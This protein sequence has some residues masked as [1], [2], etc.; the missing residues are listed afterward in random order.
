MHARCLGASTD[1]CQRQD[2]R[3]LDTNGT[4]RLPDWWARFSSQTANAA[5]A[6][7]LHLPVAT[8]D[9]G[10]VCHEW[11]SLERACGFEG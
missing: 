8:V 3:V 4:H 7:L 11:A 1:A 6:R 9:V 10:L 5:R 2:L